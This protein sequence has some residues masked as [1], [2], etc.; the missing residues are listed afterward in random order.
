MTKK[1][2]IGIAAVLVAGLMA[3]R[4]AV[5]TGRGVV[6]ASAQTAPAPKPIVKTVTKVVT[7]KKHKKAPQG[8]GQVVTVVRSAPSTSVG[9]ISS[10][11]SSFEGEHEREGDDGGQGED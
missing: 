8:S 7:V 4:V 2:A 6:N 11:G 5:T 1:L 9:S 10:S 3:G